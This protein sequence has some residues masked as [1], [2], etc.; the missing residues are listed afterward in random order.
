M[1]CIPIV[2]WFVVRKKKKSKR[3]KRA[4]VNGFV[5]PGFE[6]VKEM[7]EQNFEADLEAEAQCCAYV[8]EEKVMG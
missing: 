2:I 1:F 4:K 6:P 5:A 7:F 8:G 3:A